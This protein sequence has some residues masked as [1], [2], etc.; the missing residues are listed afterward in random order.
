MKSGTLKTTVGNPD[1]YFR[2]KNGKYV[3]VVYTTQQEGIFKKIKEDIEKCF[4]TTKTKLQI[5]EIE[6]IVCCHTSSNL[7]YWQERMRNYTNFV[8]TEE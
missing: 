5:N 2:N 1:T 7:T 3:C 8:R 4:D 6:E